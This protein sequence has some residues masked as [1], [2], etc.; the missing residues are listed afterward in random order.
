MTAISAPAAATLLVDDSVGGKGAIQI[1]ADSTATITGSSLK[2]ASIAF[3][4]PDA[5]LTLAQG[6]D[7][8]ASISGFAIGDI[9]AMAHI[10]AV[11]FAASTGT[12]TLGAHNA[13]VESLH[14]VGNFTGD[15]FGVQQTTGDA[16]ITLHH[17]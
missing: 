3:I 17:G 4:G 8:T 10:D 2:L 7:V 12:L 9:I 6:S 5:T 14:L 13:T 16:L 15:T 11:T 1:A